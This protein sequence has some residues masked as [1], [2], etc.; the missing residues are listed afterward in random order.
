[1]EIIS[2]TR[3]SYEIEK[4][5]IE[6][7]EYLILVTPYL[8]LNQRLKVKLSDT[9]NRVP[10]TYIVYRENS[11]QPGDLDW[12]QSFKNVRLF[13]IKNLHS[14]IY[15][16][17]N[18]GIIA[19][20][21]LYEY[22]QINNHEIGVIFDNYQDNLHK[23]TL[24]EIRMILETEY[25]NKFHGFEEVFEKSGFYKMGNLFLELKENHY[26]GVRGGTQKLYEHISNLARS[27]VD[28]S[29][30]ELYQDKTAI[31]RDTELGKERYS[32]LK[33]KLEELAG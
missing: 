27:I 1:M 3:I 16:N 17:E 12:L 24:H 18:F 19:S 15:L 33:T 2:T 23:S 9:L 13:S 10:F 6:A 21:N 31:L 5:L 28:F 32:L 25:D 4:L 22:S 7:S 11:L 8:K 20:M 30:D 26:W 29:D 14:K